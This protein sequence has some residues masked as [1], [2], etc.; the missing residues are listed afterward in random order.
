[1]CQKCK[2]YLYDYFQQ[3]LDKENP[4]YSFVNQKQVQQN[5]SELAEIVYSLLTSKS[6][7]FPTFSDA[8][9]QLENYCTFVKK[10][11][12]IYQ[13][14]E[15]LYSLL[16]QTKKVVQELKALEGTLL[17]LKFLK[18]EKTDAKAQIVHRW[19]AFLLGS[20]YEDMFIL[21]QQHLGNT[22]WPVSLDKGLPGRPDTAP[23]Q[24][25]RPPGIAVQ[26]VDEDDLYT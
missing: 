3:P 10:P 8:R 14:Y 13:E 26:I 16:S 6:L 5:L 17:D 2:V 9:S 24:F 15:L 4:L 11:D 21:H 7:S 12:S 19:F 23:K 25:R 20:L 22:R 1:M 18:L